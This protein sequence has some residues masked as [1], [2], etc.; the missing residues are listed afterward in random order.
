VFL[1]PWADAKSTWYSAH[2]TP[3]GSRRCK[4]CIA[5]SRVSTRDKCQGTTLVVPFTALK[6]KTPCAAGPRTAQERAKKIQP[7]KPTRSVCFRPGFARR[8]TYT[9]SRFGQRPIAK[10]QQPLFPYGSI[11]TTSDAVPITS[12][13]VTPG[14]RV[15]V[16]VSKISSSAPWVT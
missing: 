14:A 6:N 7:L 9:R 11:C 1:R 16:P 3:S 2:E 8:S 13:W 5:L 10:S 15:S 4:Y 12:S